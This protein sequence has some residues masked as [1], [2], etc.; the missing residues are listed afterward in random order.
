MDA[1]KTAGPQNGARPEPGAVMTDP[2]QENFMADLQAL[3][4]K[5]D[6]ELEVGALKKIHYKTKGYIIKFIF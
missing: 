4:N 3:L 6:A 5:H 1:D 2:R